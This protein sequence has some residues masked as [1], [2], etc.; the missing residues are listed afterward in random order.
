MPDGCAIAII[1][2]WFVVLGGGAVYWFID[3]AN[4]CG[5][6]F[7]VLFVLAVLFLLLLHKQP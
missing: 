3:G 6:L 4:C 1:V 2:A 7:L 5:W